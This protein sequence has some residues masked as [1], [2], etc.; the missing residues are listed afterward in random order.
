MAIFGFRTAFKSLFH[1]KSWMSW[2]TLR[3]NARVISSMYKDVLTPQKMPV[4]VETF[5]EAMQRYGYSEQF[6]QAQ[7]Q[8]FSKAARFYLALLGL[9]FCYSLWL[10]TKGYWTAFVVMLP[11]NLML[12]SF[13]FRESFWR[14]QIKKRKLGMSFKDWFRITVLGNG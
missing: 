5:E 9:G 3:Q 14:L 12:F 1:F 8:Q 7:M 10:Y 2:S 4:K 6:L 11:F 13:Y